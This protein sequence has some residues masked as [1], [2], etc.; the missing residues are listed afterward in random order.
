MTS[1]SVTSR[2]DAAASAISRGLSSTRQ[3]LFGD[4]GLQFQKIA[5]S[6][7]PQYDNNWL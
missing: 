4:K 7:K 1:F 3:W 5:P 6:G 2:L